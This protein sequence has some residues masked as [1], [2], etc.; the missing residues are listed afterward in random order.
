MDD[1]TEMLKAEIG[2]ISDKHHQ[3]HHHQH[4][5]HDK[6]ILP[7]PEVTQAVMHK[8]HTHPHNQGKDAHTNEQHGESKGEGK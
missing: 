3:H 6:I 1:P 7:S 5:H 4:H 8:S 2:I